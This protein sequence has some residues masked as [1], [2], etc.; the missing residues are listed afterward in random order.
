[1]KSKLMIPV[2]KVTDFMDVVATDC[3]ELESKLVWLK[4][5]L[6]RRA[7]STDSALRELDEMLMIV[8]R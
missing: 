6:A 1:M 8:R 4:R 2:E 7:I 5:R 3:E